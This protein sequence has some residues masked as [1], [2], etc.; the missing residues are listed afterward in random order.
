M[1][2][3]TDSSDTEWFDAPNPLCG[4]PGQDRAPGEAR[5]DVAILQF[6]AGEQEHVDFSHLDDLQC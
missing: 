4:P 3:P 1:S 2:P 6:C 5:G